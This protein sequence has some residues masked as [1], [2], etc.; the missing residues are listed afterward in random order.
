MTIH[1]TNVVNPAPGNYTYGLGYGVSQNKYHKPRT[2]G[3]IYSPK[4]EWDQQLQQEDYK[5]SKDLILKSKLEDEL[6]KF[7]ALLGVNIVIKNKINKTNN[8]AK[9]QT[10]SFS[11][12]FQNANDSMPYYDKFAN[13]GAAGAGHTTINAGYNISNK[14][15]MILRETI[16]EIISEMGA[17]AFAF[18]GAKNTGSGNNKPYVKK[19]VVGSGISRSP[20]LGSQVRR[21]R[22]LGN[23]DDGVKGN[24]IHDE[25]CN[26]CDEE[27]YC[28]CN[29]FNFKKDYK[30]R[31]TKEYYIAL[32][33][34]NVNR[35]KKTN[36]KK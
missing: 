29:V 24:T 14:E 6:I 35:F 4:S 26:L 31:G 18:K 36:S 30:V 8:K 23:S 27:L 16:R 15:E 34:N 28:N 9:F 7:F 33:N 2:T 25:E 12:H 20:G 21:S 13:V 22:Q 10:K 19:H 11:A 1:N 32:D 5:N 3:D 17:T